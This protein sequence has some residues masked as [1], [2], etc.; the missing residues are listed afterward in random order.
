MRFRVRGVVRRRHLDDHT[1]NA[2]IRSQSDKSEM[3]LN[4]RASRVLR[5][6]DPKRQRAGERVR[7]KLVIII[8][9]D[10]LI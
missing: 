10:L 1:R 4:N 9:L 3:Q 6:R 2:H 7:H 8:P 5:V